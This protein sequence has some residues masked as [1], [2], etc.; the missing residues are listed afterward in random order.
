MNLTKSIFTVIVAL[1]LIACSSKIEGEAFVV[2]KGGESKKL[3]L[4]EVQAYKMSD[5]DEFKKKLLTEYSEFIEKIAEDY[6]FPGLQAIHDERNRLITEINEANK[7]YEKCHI[8]WLG[9]ECDVKLPKEVA[10][11]FQLRKTKIKIDTLAI[12]ANKA[13]KL[14]KKFDLIYLAGRVAEHTKALEVIKTKTDA[15]GK[16]S[17]T[18]PSGEFLIAATGSR[19]SLGEDYFW[20]VHTNKSGSIR[21]AN[22]SMFDQGCDT[23]LFSKAD[24]EQLNEK[25]K[26]L[27]KFINGSGALMMAFAEAKETGIN[28]GFWNT[29]CG[30][31]STYEGQRVFDWADCVK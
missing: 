29:L 11:D 16:F 2:T 21:L 28:E 31:S 19:Q 7:K 14:D 3:G 13:V 1:L 12:I 8:G 26:K 5:I 4:V 30:N 6:K 27:N 20:L 15:D 22:D 18:L 23:C 24:I 25:K 17:M 10:A 9:K